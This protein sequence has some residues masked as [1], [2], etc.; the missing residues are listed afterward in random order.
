MDTQKLLTVPLY[1]QVVGVQVVAREL[2]ARRFRDLLQVDQ[3][4]LRVGGCVAT[5]TATDTATGA[6]TVWQ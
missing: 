1:S 4:S 2:R 3:R 6:A 5:A